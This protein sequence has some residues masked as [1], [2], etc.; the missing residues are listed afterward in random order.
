MA[1]QLPLALLLFI[2]GGWAWVL[3]G[4]SLRIWAS[5][6]GHWMVGHFAHRGGHQGWYIAG[7]PVQGYNLR[8]LGLL[9]FGE[10]WHGNHHAFPHS[11]KLGIERGQ[12]D[13]GFLLIRI[14]ALLGLA[15][16]IR[17]PA[18]APPP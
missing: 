3:W 17:L 9:T 7:L 12:S 10:N 16:N 6:T 1:Q 18:S 11:A 14:L 15:G 13:P 5:L 4:I 8:G 2:L